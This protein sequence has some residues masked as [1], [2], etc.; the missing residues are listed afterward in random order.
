MMGRMM[1]I[2]F[3]I[4]DFI[5]YFPV[6]SDMYPKDSPGLC[7]LKNGVLAFKPVKRISLKIR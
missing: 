1:D 2:M 3:R 7:Q 4:M 6:F 5:M